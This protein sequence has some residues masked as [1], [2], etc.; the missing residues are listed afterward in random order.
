M[1]VRTADTAGVNSDQHLSR[2]RSWFGQ[3]A[4]RQWPTGFFDDHRSHVLSIQRCLVAPIRWA[5]ARYW[6]GFQ[7]CRHLAGQ[8]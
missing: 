6:G 2:L 1:Q 4:L 3:V 7:P 5:A 8:G